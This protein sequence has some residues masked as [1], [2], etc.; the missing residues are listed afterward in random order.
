MWC[1]IRMFSCFELIMDGFSFSTI[2]QVLCSFG[3]DEPNVEFVK[4]FLALL[5]CVFK[6]LVG[7]YLCYYFIYTYVLL[8]SIMW[9]VIFLLVAFVLQEL[10]KWF[11]L[12]SCSFILI[13]WWLSPFRSWWFALG[14]R[15]NLSAIIFR[16]LISQFN[17]P[18]TPTE[19]YFKF[20]YS[21]IF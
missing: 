7:G 17:L 18:I 10:Q 12:N 9:I 11:T 1:N 2:A 3:S 15:P 21:I 5:C 20:I 19:C 13:Y 14:P 6:Y 16:F 8:T 4:W